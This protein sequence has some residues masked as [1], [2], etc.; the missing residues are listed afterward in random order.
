MSKKTNIFVISDIWF[1]R[2]MGE[3]SFMTNDEYN[4]MIIDN[5]NNVVS[6]DDIVYILGGFGIGDCYDIVLKLNGEIHFLNSVFSQS[7]SEFMELIKESVENSVDVELHTRIIFES[8]QI[9]V[10][11]KEDCILSYF[12]LNDW[13]GKTTGTFCLHGYTNRHNLNDNNISCKFE[14]WENSPM[15]I[16]EVKNSL[17][18]LRKVEIEDLLG[19]D[20]IKVNLDEI[21]DYV[22]GKVILVTGGGG[23]IGSELCR[24]IAR[25]HFF[26]D[27]QH[28]L[29]SLESEQ[30]SCVPFRYPVLDYELLYVWAEGE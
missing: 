27:L 20:P 5:W 10:V 25:Y 2:P 22:C 15:N 28:I 17:S 1:N 29:L 3:F 9:V 16:K 23:S 8:N 30:C 13:S 24:Q 7:D 6:N 11:P 26:K 4:D 12:P 19:R 14:L 21:M 18:K